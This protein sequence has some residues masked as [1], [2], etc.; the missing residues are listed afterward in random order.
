MII[1]CASCL[2]V[3]VLVCSAALSCLAEQEKPKSKL[4]S[5]E[6]ETTHWAFKP[7]IR[8]P[9]PRIRN[10]AWIRNPID[11]FV[12]A[13]QEKQHMSPSPE[14]DRRVLIR[15]LTLD[16][17]GLPPTRE[18]IEQFVNDKSTEAY[19]KVVNRL[20]NSPHYGERWGRHWLD[21]AR[22]AESDGYEANEIRPHAW[23]YRD[24]VVRS[25]NANKPYDRFLRE[26]IAG[27][28]LEPY[29]DEN[30]IATG[31][32]AG[33]R[34]NNNEEDKAVQLNEPLVDMANTVATV[35]LGLTLGCAQCHDHK[36]EP[37][38]IHDYYAFHGFFV[39]GQV[40]SLLLKDEALWKVW[41]Q[42]WPPELETARKLRSQLYDPVRDRLRKEAREKLS[43]ELLAALD[44]SAQERS[45][46]QRELAKKAEKEIEV[47]ADK[48]KKA[49]SDD[50]QKL[51]AELDKKIS[52]LEKEQNEKKPQAWGFYSPATSPHKIEHL[53]PR[54][55]YPFPYKPDVLRTNQ[56]I[57]LKRGDIHQPE[58]TVRP[59]V[60]AALLA[61]ADV[62]RLTSN[63]EFRIPN[64]EKSQS[65]LASAAPQLNSRSALVDW[66]TSA[67]S[68]LTARVW[69]NYLWQQ[70]FG[71]GLVATPADFGTHGAKPS[72]PELLDWLAVELRQSGW[73]TKH[74]HRLIVTSSAYRQASTPNADNE[75]ID[76]EN[77]YLWRWMPR[78]L[79]SE[80]IRDAVLAVSGE[81]D[82]SVGG[83]SD[84]S[85]AKSVRRSLYLRQHRFHLPAALALF[86]AP[87]G[88]E[89][90]AR[91]YVSTVPL[92]P[93]HL[94]N[95][96]QMLKRAEGFA[97][98][99]QASAG[100]DRT[101]Q[102][103]IAFELA[104]GRA[105]EATELAMAEKL[106]SADRYLPESSGATNTPTNKLVRSPGDTLA[107]TGDS[108]RKGIAATKSAEPP[109][110]ASR[111]PEAPPALVHF[112]H[113][114]LNL[115]EFIY[116]D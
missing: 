14:A 92:Q 77:R 105:P 97:A 112:C 100:N 69:V 21:L 36:F 49:L 81:L 7:P 98:H 104:L 70:H 41:E 2:A 56:P 68:P 96:E 9:L 10:A 47:P 62:R 19:E 85:D 106:F 25:F 29:A 116:I 76:P 99:V 87:I 64:S 4:A 83:P 107:P 73:S 67:A 32:L 46:E 54:G 24:Y 114:L 61:A 57:V 58:E 44:T 88:N 84:P 50:D 75:G 42:Q 51:L 1:R 37:L 30:L 108:D 80:A 5:H 111:E 52:K 22:W 45:S 59:G 23:R 91:R 40:N 82:K 109:H 74:I 89:S 33:T 17:L 43:S 12:A 66:L 65:L 6:A 79:E 115:N 13:E 18:E 102:I 101:N 90:C 60:P 110:D 55:M 86:D 11:A 39:R 78:R 93:L 38:T 28:E 63:S 34:V 53:Q 103:R 95:N 16:L 26:Q 20:L 8:P 48:V 27:D 15:R 94:L 72:H 31:F 113:A 3:T 71:R 35:T